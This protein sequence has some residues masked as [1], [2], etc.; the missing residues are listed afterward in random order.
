MFGK[1]TAGLCVT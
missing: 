1:T